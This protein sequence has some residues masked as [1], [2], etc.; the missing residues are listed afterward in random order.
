[1]RMLKAVHFLDAAAASGVGL[2]R[3]FSQ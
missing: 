2:L 1:L 3:R